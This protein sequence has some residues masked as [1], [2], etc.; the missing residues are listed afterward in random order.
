MD[1]K[2]TECGI[3]DW[4]LIADSHEHSSGP[5]NSIKG[6]ELIDQLR[7]SQLLWRYCTPR[8]KLKTSNNQFRSHFQLFSIA[9]L[10]A[11]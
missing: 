3:V 5:L 9:S 6:K 4:T 7:Y 11:T 10:I 2:E 1:F 8:S